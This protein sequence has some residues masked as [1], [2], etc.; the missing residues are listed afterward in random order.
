MSW[1]LSVLRQY[2]T[3]KG[4]ARRKEYWMFVLC[5]VPFYLALIVIDG[6]TGTFDMGTERGLLSGLFMIGTLLP[7]LAVAVRRLHDTDRSGWWLLLS[8]IP[9]VGQIGLLYFLIQEGD[10]GDN[11]YGRDPRAVPGP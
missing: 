10:E 5:Y 1:F 4:R 9:I 11:E 2:A 7:S 8:L 3:F 6:L